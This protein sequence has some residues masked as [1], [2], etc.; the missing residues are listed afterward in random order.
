MPDSDRLVYRPY[1]EPMDTPLHGTRPECAQTGRYH[2]RS[3]SGA[4]SYLVTL[5]MTL[6]ISL[7][8]RMYAI[9]GFSFCGLLGLAV[10]QTSNLATSLREQRQGELKHLAELALSI[11]REEYEAATQNIVSDSKARE[12][13]AARIGKLRYGNGDYFWINDLRPAM[14]MHPIK[15]ELDRQ[16]LRDIKDPAGK[17]LF[18]EFTD[19]VKLEGQGFVD[20]QWPKPGKDTPQPKLSYVAGFQPWNWVIGTGVYVDD[21]QA[22]I[23]DQV[24][25]VLT[26]AAAILITLGA[27]TLLLARR[28]SKAL[29]E[30]TSGLNRLGEGDFDMKLPGLGRGDELGDMARSIDQFRLK[31][32][33]KARQDLEQDYERR[34]LAEVAK[35]RALQEMAENVESATNVAV[36]EVAA[37][38]DR[39]A[40]NA[41]MMTDTALTLERNS[42]SVAAA[43][44]EALTNAQTV[45]RA[46]SQLAG[47]I[48]QIADQVGASRSLTLEA[49][50]ASTKAQA[51]MSKLSEAASKVGVVTNLISEIAGQTNLLALNATIEAARAGSAGRGFAVVAAEVKSLAE[52]T[53]RATSE[54]AQQISEIQD[55]THASVLS[56]TTIGEVIRNVETVSSTISSAIEEQNIVTAGISRT[57]AET[58]HAAR[59]VAS[60]IASVSAEATET[61]RRAAEIRDGSMTISEKVDELRATLI[62]VIR[63]STSDVDRRHASRLELHCLGSLLLRGESKSVHVRDISLEATL[64]E[65]ALPNV[66]IGEPVRLKIDG[67]PVELVGAIAR[68]DHQT[69]LISLHLVDDAKQKLSSVLSTRQPMMAVA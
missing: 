8:H 45:A 28:V 10:A 6:R 36:G 32:A 66:D 60:Q 69:A 34:R 16:D 33:E 68:K 22:Q 57:V 58:S 40:R 39:M 48:A 42:S 24:R 13:A 20:Y 26:V 18:V 61:G 17:R 44:E 67:I 63:T 62:R 51:T 37:G 27:V 59:E 7:A 49:V 19:V 56:M 12:N 38:T 43:A 52:Q 64:I 4:R 53:A 1:I 35:T 65:C 9:I 14:I 2:A 41:S 25:S 5:Q 31:A 55:A 15:P 54:I 29:L 46:S 11:A 23:W 21:L 50:T 47:S 30:M 3:K